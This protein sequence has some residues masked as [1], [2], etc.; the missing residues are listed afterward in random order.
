[1]EDFRDVPDAQSGGW[2]DSEEQKTFNKPASEIDAHGK[3]KASMLIVEIDKNPSEKIRISIE[4]YRGSRFVDCRVYWKD[5]D[6][7]WKPSKKGLAVSRACIDEVIAGLQNAR[8]ALDG[9]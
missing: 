7:E 2:N 4:D 9:E 3:G 8:A 1:M 5:K 6:G